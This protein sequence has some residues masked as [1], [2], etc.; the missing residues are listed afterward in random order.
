[1][2]GFDVLSSI[3]FSEKIGLYFISTLT[4]FELIDIFSNFVVSIL[5][6]SSNST[7]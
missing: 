2:G 5:T 3:L 6:G 1:M 4:S 7:G